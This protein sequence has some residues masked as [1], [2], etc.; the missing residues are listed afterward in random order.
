MSTKDKEENLVPL[1]RR[2]E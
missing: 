2:T 1:M